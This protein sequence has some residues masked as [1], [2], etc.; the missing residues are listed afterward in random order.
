MTVVAHR[1]GRTAMLAFLIVFAL[2]G[3]PA[4]VAAQTGDATATET[5]TDTPTVTPTI[6]PTQTPPVS[7]CAGDC[8][9]RYAVTIDDLMRAVAVALGGAPQNDC[10][11]ADINRDGRV[12]V[13]ELVAAVG[14]AL[15]GCPAMQGPIITF[16]GLLQSDNTLIQPEP[17]GPEGVPVYQRQFGFGFSL[18]VEARRGPSGASPGMSAFADAGCP[19]LQVQVTN[20]LGNG[21]PKVCGGIMEGVPPLSQPNLSEDPA[22]CDAFNDLGCRFVNGNNNPVAR[23]CSDGCVKFDSGESGCASPAPIDNSTIQFCGLMYRSLDFLPGDT[24]VT[25]RVRDTNSNLG[26]P[27]QIIVRVTGP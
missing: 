5:P 16:F 15:H 18:V 3:L 12:T 21:N 9:A 26:P 22:L 13:D 19:D 7:S 17:I 10:L 4:P 14:S 6:T 1:N 24:L 20:P 25:A 2:A 27:A 23:R 11:A 8:D